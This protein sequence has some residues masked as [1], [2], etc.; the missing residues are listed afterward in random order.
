MAEKIITSIYKLQHE[1]ASFIN[2]FK[3]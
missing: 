2:Y 3:K 1:M